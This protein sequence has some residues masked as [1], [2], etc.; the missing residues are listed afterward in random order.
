MKSTSTPYSLP[1]SPRLPFRKCVYVLFVCLPS[2]DYE[3][4]ES[5]NLSCSLLRPQGLAHGRTQ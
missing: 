4:G 5:R 1:S 2:L 3:L